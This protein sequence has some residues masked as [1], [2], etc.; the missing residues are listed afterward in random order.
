[1]MAEE[2]QKA[3]GRGLCFRC[4]K[5]AIF[6]ETGDGPRFECKQNGSVAS[7]YCFIPCKPIAVAP[8][9]GEKRPMFGPWMIAGRVQAQGLVDQ[10]R[11]R[12]NVVGVDDLA[13]AAIWKIKGR[14]KEGKTSK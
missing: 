8:I 14:K 10:G 7:C 2:T 11:L 5:R 6:N 9:A 4:E 3:I 13:V 1:M 12:L